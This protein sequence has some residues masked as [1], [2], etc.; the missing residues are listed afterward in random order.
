[1]TI[2]PF[3]GPIGK[4]G[5]VVE[6]A[7]LFV[8]LHWTEC[9]MRV[10]MLGE[11]VIELRDR[12][13]TPTAPH[14]FA[15]LL[16]LSADAGRFFQRREL[17]HLLFPQ[18]PDD[19]SATHSVRQLIYQALQRG[20]RIDK[21]GG[22]VALS[23]T[24]LSV[25][26]EDALQQDQSHA[27]TRHRTLAVL[28]G[29][30]P[31]ISDGFDEWLELYR[32][33]QQSRVRHALVVAIGTLRKR[34]DWPAVEARSIECL[35]LDPF[36]EPATLALA[37]AL[38]R[39]GSKE[40]A[41]T[42]LEAYRKEV[43]VHDP[44]IALPAILLRKRIEGSVPTV[45]PIDV[46]LPLAARGDAISSLHDRW[47]KA[48]GGSV[49]VSLIR[50]EPGSGKSR[51]IEE[52]YETVTLSGKSCIV[53]VR[54]SALEHFHPFSFFADLVR[55]LLRFPGSAGC[56][57]RLLPF[58]NRLTGGLPRD[59]SDLSLPD[60][61]QFI[62]SGIKRA[63]IDLLDAIG[64]EKSIV[65]LID[66]S[67]AIDDVSLALLGDL[68]QVAPALPL[69]MVIACDDSDRRDGLG[70]LP[71]HTVHLKPLTEDESR[72]VLVSWVSTTQHV[73]SE[74]AIQWCVNIA[75]GNPAFLQ[76]LAAQASASPETL[77]VPRDIVAAVDRRL[78]RLS[79]A[80]SR[81]L[82]ACAV[83]GDHCDEMML[84]EVIGLA[85]FSLVQ[86]LHELERS[87]LIECIG[88]RVFLR[89]ALFRDRTISLA[90]RSVLNL[91]HSRSALAMERQVASGNS[92]WR[93]A[94]HWHSA[95][96]LRRARATLTTSW[97]RSLQLGQPQHAEESIREYLSLTTDTGERVALYED[98]IEATQAAGNTRATICAIDERAALL[99]ASNGA[100]ARR[101]TFLFDRI[102]AQ[103]QDHADPSQPERELM[104]FMLSHT[105]DSARRL[106]AAQR[107]L[108]SADATANPEL[109]KEVHDALNSFDIADSSARAYYNQSLLIYHSV[110]G[111]KAT[112][113]SVAH[114]I[115]AIARREPHSWP[116]IRGR[117][118][119]SLALRVACNSSE[120]ITNLEESYGELIAAGATPTC[121]LVASRLASFHLDD[122]DV[123]TATQWA[124]RAEVHVSTKAIGRLPSEYLSAQADLAMIAGDFASA[125]KLVATMRDASPL[126]QAPRFKMELLS[127]TLRLAQYE[128]R[129]SS[130]ANVDELLAWH[131][132]ARSYGRHDDDMDALWVALVQQQRGSL[133]SRLLGDYLRSHRRE[134]RSCGHFLRTRTAGDPAWLTV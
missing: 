39:M 92:S 18:A 34:S 126:Y 103:L 67:R 10:R 19:R 57:P 31:T 95:G 7:L 50:G 59:D 37:E 114:D 49:Q 82:E 13:Y 71:T 83:L 45:Q 97:R 32:A 98:L 88:A 16:R 133:A 85:A 58:L 129:P 93:I 28:P 47:I 43:G 72:G 99:R 110:F 112:A 74:E 96:Q 108:A 41:V 134:S 27:S 52:F 115:I 78:E 119:A 70:R 132:R 51:L 40:R 9:L 24:S 55:S 125:L 111:D 86:A 6:T 84:E 130:E 22:A 5:I 44:Q 90:S 77:D 101:E 123:V 122:G 15:L 118:N 25:D 128:G 117:V 42:L 63:I 65:I 11:C 30:F 64:A 29:Y 48:C 17:G 91:L 14:F 105:L 36:S 56:D 3:L 116:H 79:S 102:D 113:L 124:R 106:R 4:N 94:S 109:A 131:F 53:A 46:R 26:L 20:A 1:M 33:H 60:E 121:V 54:K 127:Y 12:E 76:L 87:G 21:S 80:A 75:A 104:T 89:S 69:Y 68:Q 73:L 62:S 35:S 107:L 81:V 23:Q 66:D 120:A 38:A 2:G 8:A 61:A 100:D